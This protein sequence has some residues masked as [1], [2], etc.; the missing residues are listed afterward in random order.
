MNCLLIDVGSTFIKYSVLNDADGTLLCE[1]KL[2]FPP[3]VLADGTVF[4]VCSDGIA[5]TVKRIFALSEP[6]RCRKAFFSVQMHGY[7][8]RGADGTCGDYVS[9]RDRSGD[10]SSPRFAD[11][12][13]SRFGTSRKANLPLVKI[14]PEETAG[15]G[16]FTLGSFLAWS[17]TGVNETHITDACAS[18][19][20]W[21]DSGEKNG[22]CGGMRMPRVRTDV[23]CTGQYRGIAVYTPV[24]DHQA[25]F[26]GSGAEDD[27][28]LI[29]IGTATQ[30]SCL[31]PAD[32]G[33]GPYE[34]R[35]YF[36]ESG[37]PE[38]DVRLYTVTG[39][40][41]GDLLY[42]N[43]KTDVLLSQ[44]GEALSVLPEKHRAVLG[45]GGAGLL[46]ETITALLAARGILCTVNGRNIGTEGLKRIA[47][48]KK[49]KVGVMHSE[50]PF[51][52]F[53]IIAKNS[54]L[55]FVIL[56]C[57]H[58]AFDYA[59]TEGILTTANLTGLDVIVRIGDSS[60]A[61]VT[62]LADMGA[63]GFLLPMTDTADD[64][65]AL[66]GYAKYAPVGHRGVSTTRAHTLYDP[67][68]L[69]D[70]IVSANERMKIYAQIETRAGVEHLKE[71]LSVPGI[72]GIFVGPNDLS[73]DLGCT[74][75]ERKSILIDTIRGIAETCV[76]AGK[77]W[78]IITG[79]KELLDVSVSC[80]ASMVS[81][82]SELNMLISGCKKVKGMF[83]D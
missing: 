79:D 68:A 37:D 13:F 64:I 50:I 77:P 40:V 57:E 8:M 24:G 28:Y 16:F 30:V 32:C 66:V 62:K 17:L 26:F 2:P 4:R 6:Y 49:L 23:C 22:F 60:R 42:K 39:L 47:M 78:G 72:E 73:M 74:G 20:F 10:P 18:G 27:A 80:G 36:R 55:D 70:Y 52:N 35:P 38:Q 15:C 33:D 61:N 19:F 63:H 34:K 29:N 21:A 45:G 65:A 51:P 82:G 7:I 54:G 75:K 67:P 5:E 81:V 44:L 58:G 31:A 83:D 11:A 43:E 41:G 71:I 1:E 76:R 14:K 12:D 25:S 56:D 46:A 9:W 59:V 53:P 69:A 3:P 48:D